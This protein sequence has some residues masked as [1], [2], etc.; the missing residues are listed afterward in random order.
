MKYVRVNERIFAKEVR[1][2]GP[3]GEQ[4]GVLSRDIALEKA[5]GMDLDLVEVAPQANPPVCRITDFSKYKY[6][7]KKR[8][9]EVKKHQKQVQLKEVRISPRIGIH[10]Y[11]VKFKHV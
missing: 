1:T 11:G 3:G 9:K 2:V 4:L 5:E 10:D 8:E 6:E 7:Q